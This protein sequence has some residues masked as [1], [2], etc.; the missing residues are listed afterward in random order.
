MITFNECRPRMARFL[1]VSASLLALA[2]CG[3]GGSGSNPGG[4]GG[5]QPVGDTTA[6][7]ISVS[8]TSFSVDSGETVNVSVSATDNVGVTSGPTVTCTNG[9]TYSNGV[10]TAPTVSAETTSECTVTASDAAGNQATATFTATITIPDTTP[11]FISISPTSF[12][13]HSGETFNVDVQVSDDVGVTSGPDVSCTEGGVF[14]NGVFTAPDV[15]VDTIVECTVTASDAAGNTASETFTANVTAPTGFSINGTVSKGLV[16]GADIFIFDSSD[17]SV[18]VNPITSA[19]LASGTTSET[20][21]SYS[22]DVDTTDITIG[23]YVIVHVDLRSAQIVCDA[24]LGCG[25][26]IAFGDTFTVSDTTEPVFLRAIV[27]TLQNQEQKIV[28]VNIFSHL[29]TELALHFIDVFGLTGVRAQDIAESQTQISRIFTLDDQPFVDLSFIDLTSEAFAGL[30]SNDITANIIAA[31]IMGAIGESSLD[32]TDAFDGFILEFTSEEGELIGREVADNSNLVSLQD[33]FENAYAIKDVNNSIDPEFLNVLNEI[34]FQVMEIA[35]SQGDTR[36]IDGSIRFS[37]NNPP[38]F[39]TGVEYELSVN[40]TSFVQIL[41]GDL[42]FDPLTFTLDPNGDGQFFNLSS[43]GELTFATQLDVNNPSDA[44]ADNVY[45]LR[46]TLSDGTDAVTQTIP[47]TVTDSP[48][49]GFTITGVASKGL[50][51]GA[52][53]EIYNDSSDVLASLTSSQTDGRFSAEISDNAAVNDYITVAAIF[54]DMTMICD[55]PSGC[56]AGI[57]F[58][59]DVTFPD[60]SS[61]ALSATL[62]SP[63]G[64]STTDVH[65]N[66]MTQL[67]SYHVG[68]D[69]ELPNSTNLAA[70]RTFV[71]DFFNIPAQEFSTLEFIDVTDPALSPTDVNAMTASLLSAGVFAAALENPGRIENALINFYV[72]FVNGNVP[73]DD[74]G[75]ATQISKVDIL[76][77]AAAIRSLNSSTNAIFIQA[78]D[79][80]DADLAAI[81][82]P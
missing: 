3:G 57:N 34:E 37:G 53:I 56:G 22:I 81:N 70:S 27:P 35:R 16:L 18:R 30:A 80:I 72:A 26:G 7:N 42:E 9:G 5:G 29:Q 61:V 17:T 67:V 24:A 46:I 23:D 43:S 2:A 48:P 79:K 28:N 77:H 49:A 82:P 55:A 51:K 65:I 1:F 11:P 38:S 15:S 20:D 10:F 69:V 14:S 19:A 33:I 63:A 36:T 58:G 47:V 44:N 6:P 25:T 45:E 4:G 12:T 71:G 40:S 54:G 62:L 41:A 59:D 76:T 8:P 39:V 21:G 66:L 60:D 52:T 31:G 73:D 75:D 50:M 78:L 32:F 64:G 13:V 68:L 74:N